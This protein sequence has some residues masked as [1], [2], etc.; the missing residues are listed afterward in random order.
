MERDL[1]PSDFLS[2]DSVK[3]PQRV[4]I[5]CTTTLLYGHQTGIPR[6]VKNL[7]LRCDKLSRDFHIHFSPLVFFLGRSWTFS[8]AELTLPKIQRLFKLKDRIE[9]LLIYGLFHLNPFRVSIKGLLPEK[10]HNYL[11]IFYQLFNFIWYFFKIAVLFPFFRFRAVALSEK[12]LVVVADIFWVEQVLN[13]LEDISKKGVTIVPIIYDLFLLKETNSY[14]KNLKEKFHSSFCRLLSI[15]DGFIGISN[16]TL[17]EIVNFLEKEEFPKKDFALDYFYPGS[18]FKNID[19]DS[20]EKRDIRQWPKE[21]WEG[22]D[23][24]LMVGTLEP[25]KNYGF[26]LDAFERMWEKGMGLTLLIIGRIGWKCEELLGRLKNSPYRGEKLF[27]Y[28]DINDEELLFCYQNASALILASYAEGFGLPMI[29]AMR[30][31]LPVL[32]SDMEVFREIGGDY[33]IYFSLNS[34]D[35]LIEA[36]H[37]V[38]KNKKSPKEWISWDESAKTLITKALSIYSKQR[39]KKRPIII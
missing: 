14:Y 18:D 6:V 36:I 32:A 5:E 27:V 9:R 4:F 8:N 25:R 26:V 13:Q 28:H 19:S 24:Y 17:M 38:P 37:Q 10:E 33:P 34:I 21:L 15:A 20:G 2:N 22:R 16:N 31:G 11:K 1:L 29:E 3:K 23:V 39:D 12:D 30:L 35:S 7:I